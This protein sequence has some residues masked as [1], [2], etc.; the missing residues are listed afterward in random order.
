[1]ASEF[2]APSSRR[3]A[4]KFGGLAVSL[5]ALAAAC[6]EN[7]GGSEALGRVGNAPSVTTPPDLEVNDVVLLR[8]ASSLELTAVAVYEAALALDDAVPAGAVPLIERMI[9]EHEGTAAE[10]AR[11]TEAAGGIAWTCTNPWF[12][13]RIVGPI[14]ESITSNAVGFIVEVDGE[15]EPQLQ[16]MGVTG[17]IQDTVQITEQ[18]GSITAVD[19]LD[20]VEV[21]D[22]VEFTRLDAA[23]PADVLALAIAFENLASAAHQELASATSIVEAR[24]AHAQASAL[25]ARHAALLS[26]LSTPDRTDAYFSPA[27]V[28]GEVVP[29]ARSQFRSFAINSTF[30]Q[31]AQIEIKAGPGDLNNVRTSYLLQTPAANSLVYNELSCDA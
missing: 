11:L 26:F 20:D 27:L 29:D 10:M 8:T 28:G 23:V 3:D 19:P 30:N 13:E 2:N 31:T 5:G 7:R 16:V 18:L 21:G 17:P 22:E 12:M 15:S 6:G 4:L 1:M 24:V 25:E 14:L 9:L